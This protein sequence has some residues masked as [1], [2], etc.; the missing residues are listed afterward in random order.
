[1]DRNIFLVGYGLDARA[2][3]C[4]RAAHREYEKI[5]GSGDGAKVMH[6]PYFADVG[7]LALVPDE[8][9]TLY[10][11]ASANPGVLCETQR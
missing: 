9:E 2:T 7:M 4:S 10:R 1:M 3:T 11:V 6:H 5:Q 8:W